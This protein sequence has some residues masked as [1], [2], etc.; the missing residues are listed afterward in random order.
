MPHPIASPEE[1][2]N[3]RRQPAFTGLSAGT[4]LVT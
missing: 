4:V 2:M 1:A 3:G